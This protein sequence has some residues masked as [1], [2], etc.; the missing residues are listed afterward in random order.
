MWNRFV[1][2]ILGFVISYLKFVMNIEKHLFEHIESAYKKKFSEKLIVQSARAIGGGCI[3]NALKL[4]TNCGPL[5]L[6]WNSSGPNDLFLREA[7]SLT[8][9]HKSN[10]KFIIFPKPL[11][12]K[13]INH[14]PGYLLTTYL[15]PGRCGNDDEKLGRGL[16]Q[17]H[18]LSHNRF[19]FEHN[20]YCGATLQ[21]N[22]FKENWIAFYTENRIGHLL[23]LIRKNRGWSTSD[24][25]VADRFLKKVP[26]LLPAESIPSLIHGDLWSG[27]Y[28]YTTKAP[29]LIDPCV[30][31]CDRE[32]ELGMMT[33]FGGFSQ[34]VF[35]A[36]NEYSPLPDDWRSRNLIYQLY[37][38]LNHYYLFGGFYKNQALEIMKQYL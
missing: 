33:M 19:G 6:K 5:F 28:M 37:H 24:E 14:L 36:Y 7:E 10:N 32:F 26:E 12:S 18:Q 13:T 1:F 16:A 2:C 15:E 22:G 31:Y 4:E 29:A 11:L 21:D 3:S 38:V 25:K 27:N 17:L 23:K 20:N 8:E 35:D 30:S 9:F 34:K